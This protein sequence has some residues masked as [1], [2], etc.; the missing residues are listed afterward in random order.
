MS[1]RSRNVFLVSER[2]LIILGVEMYGYRER[3]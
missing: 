1:Y 3:P 2:L